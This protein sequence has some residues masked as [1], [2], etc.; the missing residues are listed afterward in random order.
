MICIK[1]P[2]LVAFTQE[3]FPEILTGNFRIGCVMMTI[4]NLSTAKCLM[5]L[6]TARHDCQCEP[7]KWAILGSLLTLQYVKDGPPT[8]GSSPGGKTPAT[9]N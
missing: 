6:S 3:N 2:H 4:Q 1:D 9:L 7:D 5:I 8:E